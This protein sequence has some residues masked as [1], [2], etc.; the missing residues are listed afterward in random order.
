MV[1]NLIVLASSLGSLS[2]PLSSSHNS[3]REA[4][5]NPQ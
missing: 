1:G 3:L 2:L 4:A 5:E